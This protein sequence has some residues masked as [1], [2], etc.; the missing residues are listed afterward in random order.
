MENVQSHKLVGGH[1]T[2]MIV[3]SRKMYHSLPFYPGL[4]LSW[5]SHHTGGK[6]HPLSLGSRYGTTG[7]EW[8]S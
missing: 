1:S 6:I 8:Q 7:K 3:E 5:M 2:K 4:D